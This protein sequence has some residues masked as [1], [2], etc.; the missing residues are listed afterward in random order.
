MLGRAAALPSIINLH[1]SDTQLVRTAPIITC[2]DGLRRA[3]RL[4]A[5]CEGTW[6][7]KDGRVREVR[8]LGGTHHDMLCAAQYSLLDSGAV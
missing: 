1:A 5:G 7:V 3:P 4:L 2:D 8:L 6:Q